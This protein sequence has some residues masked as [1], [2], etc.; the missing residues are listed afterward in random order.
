MAAGD[1]KMRKKKEKI[2]A[3]VLAGLLLLSGCAPAAQKT[4]EAVPAAKLATAAPAPETAALVTAAPETAAPAAA[5]AAVHGDVDYADMTWYKYDTDEFTRRLEQFRTAETAEAAAAEYDWLYDQLRE[6]DTLDEL[7]WIRY[8]ADVNDTELY[9]N[10]VWTDDTYNGA[11]DGLSAAVAE[12]LD[13]ALGAE[14]TAHIGQDAADY[15][16]GYEEMSQHESDL[17]AQETE[18]ELEYNQLI[19]RDDLSEPELNAQAGDLYL[20]LVALRNEIA[21]LNGYDDFTDYAYEQY[22]DRDYTPEDA[23]V[24]CGQVKSFAQRYY[25]NCYSCSVFWDDLGED[26]VFTPEELLGLLRKYAGSL[27]PTMAEAEAYMEKHGLYLLDTAENISD[28]GFTTT[29]PAYNA[30]FLYNCLYGTIHDVGD[31]VH[32]FGHYHDAY[33]NQ[34]P[35]LLTSAGSYDIFEIHSTGLE[36]L[37][38][39]WYDEIF[40]SAAEAARIYCLDGLIYNVITGCIFDEFQ[41]KVYADPPATVDEL[42]ALYSSLCG[43]Y[44]ESVQSQSAAYYWMY[45]NHNFESPLYYI[46]YAVSSLASLQIWALAQEDRNAAVSL[47]LD[48]VSRGAYA[49][50][51]C[52]LLRDVGL[53]VFTDDFDGC[54][55]AAY[56]ELENLC[57]DYDA[58]AAA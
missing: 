58:R 8:Y 5:A 19:A 22:Y 43:E 57:A 1:A 50:G 37:F 46:S 33:C 42:N 30:P 53:T 34:Q 51:Y 21:V 11:S 27:S 56:G 17:W 40:A 28:L 9:D 13:G 41:Q 39:G 20:K 10:C 52:A 15:L 24:L 49:E 7:A 44:G 29:L 4:E 54:I 47:Y 2:L 16:S 31:V 6:L 35:N 23:A 25:E 12:V 32:E 45:V 55:S 3:G 26:A 48:L 14:F 38:Y 18:L 36:V